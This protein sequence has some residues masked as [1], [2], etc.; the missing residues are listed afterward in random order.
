MKFDPDKKPKTIS[1]AVDTL[2][3]MLEPNEVEAVKGGLTVA[4]IH[5][6]FGMRLRNAWR[7]W[8]NGTAIKNDAVA[9]YGIAH[10]DDLSGLIMEWAFAKVRGDAFDPQSHVAQYHEHWREAGT[11]ALTAGN[12]K[13]AETA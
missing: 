4:E 6:S 13:A 3:S 11:D 7:L 12:W 10:G 8:D 1:E 2:V 9:T 5:S